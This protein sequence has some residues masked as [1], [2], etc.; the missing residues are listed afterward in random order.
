MPKYGTPVDQDVTQPS[1]RP[2]GKYFN[3][4][5]VVA[6]GIGNGGSGPVKCPDD[7]LV[8]GTQRFCGMVLADDVD[9]ASS[10]S[11]SMEITDSGSGK[12]TRF[13]STFALTPIFNFVAV[14]HVRRATDR[15]IP[16]ER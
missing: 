14:P 4:V 7:Y 11:A 10:P 2:I 12:A 5:N 15:A 3:I 16:H 9:R 8:I 1:N 6:A 13:S